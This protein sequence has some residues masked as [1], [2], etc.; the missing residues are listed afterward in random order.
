ML[1]GGGDNNMNRGIKYS[2]SSLFDAKWF[3]CQTKTLGNPNH[4]A[5]FVYLFTIL[6]ISEHVWLIVH[7]FII[8]L[9]DISIEDNSDASINWTYVCISFINSVL[10]LRLLLSIWN[11][12]N[13][14]K[15]I[16]W[17]NTQFFIKFE[18][19]Y[20]VRALLIL[21]F[22][23]M[24]LNILLFIFEFEETIDI[25]FD[26][27]DHD[28]IMWIT[29]ILC[30]IALVVSVLIKTKFVL[31][32]IKQLL[33]DQTSK[34]GTLVGPDGTLAL[35]S[36]LNNFS[37]N[38]SSAKN[39]NNNNASDNNNDSLTEMSQRNSKFSNF[40]NSLPGDSGEKDENNPDDVHAAEKSGQDNHNNDGN[41]ED[42]EKKKKKEKLINKHNRKTTLQN[43]VIR[44]RSDAHSCINPNDN[45]LSIGASGS[46]TSSSEDRS[47][48]TLSNEEKVSL[49]LG[50]YSNT[51][52]RI[53]Y[54]NDMLSQS[55]VLD[56]LMQYLECGFAF[57]YLLCLIEI[58]LFQT[59]IY[60]YLMH[61]KIKEDEDEYEDKNQSRPKF[62][63][64]IINNYK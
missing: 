60:E 53:I 63:V 24:I 31:E 13:K 55:K 38:T 7:Q 32:T 12:I 21:H 44:K 20:T 2:P 58:I 47:S 26:S 8:M 46:D 29:L 10:P 62:Y 17:L 41:K 48:H 40:N 30:E 6:S 45:S 34:N 23:A 37:D 18:T 49:A 57:E 22:V 54:L 4:T 59:Y 52:E 36:R 61:Q 14:C 42:K 43:L 56:L 25:D 27:G 1:H 16:A 3:V 64:K 5:R 19:K 51:K 11:Q 50:V 28:F 39:N 35:G 33:E 9:R 15:N